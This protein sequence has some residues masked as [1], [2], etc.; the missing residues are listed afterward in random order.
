M[1]FA[2]AGVSEIYPETADPEPVHPLADRSTAV[3]A[4]V[5]C[6]GM[7]SSQAVVEGEFV[8]GPN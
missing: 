2:R 5:E 6:G 1:L 8:Q 3:A 7:S 4:V